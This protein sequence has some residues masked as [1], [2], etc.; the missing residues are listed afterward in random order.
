[1]VRPRREGSA[2]VRLEEARSARRAEGSGRAAPGED[3]LGVLIELNDQPVASHDLDGVAAEEEL[4]L[5]SLVSEALFDTGP[6]LVIE[7][8]KGQGLPGRPGISL[9]RGVERVNEALGRQLD[10][11]L[12]DQGEGGLVVLIEV[13][14][15]ESGAVVEV[16]GVLAGPTLEV[17]AL[18]GAMIVVS[19]EVVFEQEASSGR[20]FPELEEISFEDHHLSQ[21]RRSEALAPAEGE[22]GGSPDVARL[23]RG[24]VVEVERRAGLP[25]AGPTSQASLSLDELEHTLDDLGPEPL[26]VVAG[27]AGDQLDDLGI[28]GQGGVRARGIGI[29]GRHQDLGQPAPDAG[30]PFMGGRLRYW[31]LLWHHTLGAV[32]VE[33]APIGSDRRSRSQRVT[34]PSSSIKPT[35]PVRSQRLP[36]DFVSAAA[37]AAGSRRYSFMIWGPATRISPVCSSPVSWISAPVAGSVRRHSVPGRG[38]PTPVVVPEIGAALTTGDAS[39][40]A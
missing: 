38:R 35:S 7:L 5:V 6:E 17:A 16:S 26:G 24:E 13:S 34:R 25:A 2:P 30:D 18:Q 10:L 31:G 4:E 1:M 15:I 32:E 36:S 27:P 3:R 8:D 29:A 21:A 39:G 9:E 33:G 22:Q 12:V 28:L 14:P 11:V 19:A 37:L 23:D 20:S 40:R